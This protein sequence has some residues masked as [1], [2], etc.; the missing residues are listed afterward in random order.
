MRVPVHRACCSL[1]RRSRPAKKSSRGRYGCRPATSPRCEAE[2]GCHPPHRPQSPY[3]WAASAAKNR[4]RPLR[5]CLPHCQCKN[6]SWCELTPKR[7]DI[8]AHVPI[9]DGGQQKERR[10]RGCGAG[11]DRIAPPGN[12][13]EREAKVDCGRKS[14][15]GIR[16]IAK[17]NQSQR[18]L[19]VR[20]WS[21][22]IDVM[23][24]LCGEGRKLTCD[25]REREREST[26][27]I[28]R[29]GKVLGSTWLSA[30]HQRFLQ[31]DAS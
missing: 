8:D 7:S 23:C 27:R 13:R 2:C 14:R 20:L 30:E 19:D 18:Q 26:G 15:Q 5:P 3:P 25:E 9:G 4:M 11:H 1:I 17:V 24:K 6:D 16:R 29:R 22:K 10:I 28:K 21:S 31:Q 12:V